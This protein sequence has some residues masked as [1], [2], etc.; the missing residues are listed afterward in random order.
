MA[1][2]RRTFIGSTAATGAAVALAGAT[3]S[4]AAAAQDGSKGS[5]PRTY[6]SP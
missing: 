3:S 5:G 2:D 6:P 1:F 4:P